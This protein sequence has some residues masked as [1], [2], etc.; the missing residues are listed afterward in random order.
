MGSG[1]KGI[2]IELGRRWLAADDVARMDVG[3]VLELDTRSLDCVDVYVD[4]HLYARGEPVVVD[5]CLGVR[6]RELV[7][8][9]TASDEETAETE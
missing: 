6:V 9:E 3:D 7:A 5:G 2:R 8:A 4:G 1:A